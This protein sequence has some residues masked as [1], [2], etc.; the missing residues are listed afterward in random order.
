[1][2]AESL[3]LLKKNN[4][5]ETLLKEFVALLTDHPLNARAKLKK[6]SAIDFLGG[7]HLG[8]KLFFVEI[9]LD[10]IE[11]AE[12]LSNTKINR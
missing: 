10:E 12:V 1:M 6:Q 5:D 8:L 9:F 2:F 4:W 11:R 7:T 3:Q